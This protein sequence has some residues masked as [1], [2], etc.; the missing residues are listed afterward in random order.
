M[1]CQRTK[2]A[3][4][5]CQAR[6]T[7]KG[8]ELT[9]E[10]RFAAAAKQEKKR[11]GRGEPAGLPTTGELAKGMEVMVTYNVK[12]D[13]DVANGARGR[14]HDVVLNDE[15]TAVSGSANEVELKHLPAYLLIEM[16]RTRAEKLDGLPKGVLPLEPISKSYQITMS[17]REKRTVK[18]TQLPLTA[19]YA[20][21]DY[22]SQGQTLTQVI[23]D[24][25][26]PP[27][28]HG[29]TPF[30][31]YVALSRSSGR[32]TI[33]LLRDFDKLLFVSG[34]C[35]ILSAEDERLEE[36]D[37]QTKKWWVGMERKGGDGSEAEGRST[38]R[39]GDG[40]IG[41]ETRTSTGRSAD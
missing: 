34:G 17:N 4:F 15:E 30:H 9:L 40:H 20:F 16:D 12:T 28:S 6:D 13:L 19:A 26:K 10:E 18:R 39:E 11:K 23:V 25:G 41:A 7:I 31:V 24:I 3:L 22:R 32:E 14:I 29:L 33:R 8:R 5:R 27:G 37:T 21:T 36:L 2:Q 1:H 35:P 38:Q